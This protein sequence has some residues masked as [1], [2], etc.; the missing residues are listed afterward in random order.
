VDSQTAVI[1]P[2]EIGEGAAGVDA[3][4]GEC[5]IHDEIARD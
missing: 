3:K 2:H 1:E 5:G 4:F